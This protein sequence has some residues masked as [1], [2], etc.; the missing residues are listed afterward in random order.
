MQ[1]AAAALVGVAADIAAAA[2]GVAADVV[3]AAAGVAAAAEKSYRC[4]PVGHDERIIPE[5]TARMI[6]VAI[7]FRAPNCWD[8]GGRHAS[9]LPCRLAAAITPC[10]KR[11]LRRSRNLLASCEPIVL[12]SG[13]SLGPRHPRR[14]RHS[15]RGG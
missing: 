10:W 3:A 11:Y 9:D 2:V 15:A 12:E 13:W 4:T 7:R 6:V 8:Q 14:G 1:I 5:S